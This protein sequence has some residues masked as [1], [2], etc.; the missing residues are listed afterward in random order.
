M[1][2]LHLCYSAAM[3]LA[4]EE[5][6]VTDRDLLTIVHQVRRGNITA[7]ERGISATTAN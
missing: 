6:Q 2:E 5:K 4:D 1:T 7:D 3:A